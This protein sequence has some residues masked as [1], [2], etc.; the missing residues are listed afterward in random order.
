MVDEDLEVM[1]K[2]SLSDVG[3]VFS[4]RDALALTQLKQREWIVTS[5][6]KRFNDDSDTEQPAEG[7]EA[8][9][10][11]SDARPS[12]WH[13]TKGMS[14]YAWQEHCIAKWLGLG[15]GTIKVVTGGGKT[16]LA[17]SIME[18]VQNSIEPNLRVA[19]VVPT[20]V[21]MHQWYH[22]LLA[23]GNLP[24]AAIGRLGGGYD[25]DFDNDRCIL[26]A[27]LASA[28]RQLPRIVNR[29][30]VGDRLLLITDEC[31]RAGAKEMSQVFKTKRRWS[32]GL[33]ATPE[34][35]DD[36]D[37][38]YDKSLLGK[39][40]GPIIYQFNLADAVRDGLVPKFVI[41]HYGLPMTSEERSR[42]ESLSRSISDAMSELRA[43]RDAD[44]DFFAWARS[45]AIRN[46]GEIG[47]M[48][49][50][51]IAD[52]SRRRELL[53]RLHSRHRAVEAL[54]EQE[55]AVNQDARIILFHE[56]IDEVIDLFLRLLNQGLPVI[57]EHS[58]L[59]NSIR[60][61]ALEQFREGTAQ[62]IVSARSLIE[63]FNVPAVDVGI[64]VASSGS[65]RQRMQ[66][67]GRVLRR[68]RG[69]NGEEK[70]SCMHVLYA[71]QSTEESIYG[72]LNWD[73]TT[74]VDRNRFYLWNVDDEPVAQP[75]PP[76]LPQATDVQIDPESLVSG[77]PYPGQYE[78][79][80]LTCD[81]RGNVRNAAGVFAV[82]T[83]DLVAAIRQVKGSGGRFRVTPRRHFVLVRVPTG[84][85]W[86]TIFVTR[87]AQPLTFA[88]PSVTHVEPVELTR[89]QTQAKAGDPYP[90]SGLSIADEDVRFTLKSGGSITKK[91]HGGEVFARVGDR[92]DDPAKGADAARLLAAS[93]DQ[94]KAGR[95]V[96]RLAINTAL[97]VLFRES[98]Q[99]YFLCA[100]DKGLEF[101]TRSNTQ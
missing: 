88:E 47:G 10:P 93:Q 56:S 74:G 98:G 24:A 30:G 77:A 21:L 6:R 85:D 80:E 71:A 3:P 1:D 67:L 63:G 27:V 32:L 4:K 7:S 48:A 8:Q 36:V 75:G 89:W 49:R 38:D 20:I 39:A 90:F 94:R 52:T 61:A 100:L 2:N 78:G 99:L 12:V 16:F 60:E 82:D 17:I 68:H 37:S 18:A 91:V 34:R 73:E 40:L 62:I 69:R 97:H 55:F 35:E 101:P 25:D 33:S 57:M 23:N 28:T 42:Y 81:A 92:A 58:E 70:T 65:V 79:V 41:H 96:S 59:P 54:I 29:V 19:V 51:F 15:R 31:H 46:K 11:E 22:A 83:G 5:G 44:G 64:I 14:R 86:E 66:S 26:I 9:S 13:L 45:L 84:E 76:R 50:R 53:N 95:Q 72:K 43:H 87:L